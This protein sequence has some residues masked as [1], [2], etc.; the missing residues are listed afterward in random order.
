MSAEGSRPR[1]DDSTILDTDLL[2][3]RVSGDQVI[4]DGNSN[5]YRSSSAAWDDVTGEVSVYIHSDL[6][7][8]G[9]DPD[10]VLDGHAG[11]SLFAISALEARACGFAV[12]RAPD[13]EEQHSRALAHALLIGMAPGKPGRRQRKKLAV[14]S[15]A[16]IL[17]ERISAEDERSAR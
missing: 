13:L 1:D 16:V 14:A 7:M 4:R 10:C 9:L 11:Y 3:R 2:Y 12:V 8:A 15:S 17:N 6:V 5:S